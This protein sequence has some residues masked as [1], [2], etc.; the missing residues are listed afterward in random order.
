MFWLN[1]AS[2]YLKSKI[3]RGDRLVL[4]ETGLN[5]VQ[6]CVVTPPAGLW[7]VAAAS[8]AVQTQHVS[9]ATWPVPA[10]VLLLK[11]SLVIE[12]NSEKLLCRYGWAGAFPGK[13]FT[14]PKPFVCLI[15][16]DWNL[17]AVMLKKKQESTKQNS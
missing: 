16:P 17:F 15:K 13:S 14:R 1:K 4:C 10:T 9:S 7:G 6:T 2:I 3:I 8:K 12:N 5:M 11:T